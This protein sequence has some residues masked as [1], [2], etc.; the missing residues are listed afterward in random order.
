MF[1]SIRSPCSVQPFSVFRKYQSVLRVPFNRSP[2]SENINPSS[3]FRSTVLRIPKISI[4]PPC[5]VQPFSVFRKISIR[6][7]CSVQPFS[8]FRKYQSVL[9]VPFNRSP[10]SENINPFPVFRST[11]LRSPVLRQISI[12][13]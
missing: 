11:V 13:P 8:I 2:Y 6:S 7:P 10:Y 5:S 4:R 9:R 3:V 12:L 1:T